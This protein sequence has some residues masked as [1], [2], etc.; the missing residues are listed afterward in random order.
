MGGL[1]FYTG[2]ILALINPSAHAQTTPPST[3]SD[4]SAAII[5]FEHLDY[6]KLNRLIFEATNQVREAEKTSTICLQSGL[7]KSRV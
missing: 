4:T 5:P 1:V 3:F 7:R 6:S 2:L